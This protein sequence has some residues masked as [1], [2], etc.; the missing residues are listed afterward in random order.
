MLLATGHK[1]LTICV[2]SHHTNILHKIIL[3][4]KHTTYFSVT[5]F[6]K[7]DIQKKKLEI[8]LNCI[9]NIKQNFY[10]KRWK[11]KSEPLYYT[12]LW[13]LLSIIWDEKFFR[14][15]L[16][17]FLLCLLSKRVFIELLNAFIDCFYL[18]WYSWLE[19]LLT[20]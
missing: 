14:F 4:R 5:I 19:M 2:V 9:T 3:I 20:V 6:C 8:S 13:Y 12:I 7:I 16:S 18:V 17:S 15:I 1:I 11:H 10:Y